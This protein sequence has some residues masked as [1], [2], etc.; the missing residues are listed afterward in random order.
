[1][2]VQGRIFNTDMSPGSHPVIQDTKSDFKGL[3]GSGRGDYQDGQQQQQPMSHF[4]S[5]FYDLFTVRVLFS[6]LSFFFRMVRSGLWWIVVA[7]ARDKG[8]E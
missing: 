3:A 6:S 8:R 5:L 7:E 1:M 4:H 2:H